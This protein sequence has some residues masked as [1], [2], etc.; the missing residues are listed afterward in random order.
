M[1]TKFVLM[2]LMINYIKEYMAL[3]KNPLG[4]WRRAT[5]EIYWDEYRV[6]DMLGRLWKYQY[7]AA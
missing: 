3:S 2:I 1:L 4:G 6:L 5:I 7:K